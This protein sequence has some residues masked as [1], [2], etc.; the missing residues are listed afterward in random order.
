MGFDAP[1]GAV[2]G[3]EDA[4][5]SRLGGC[6]GPRFWHA[7]GACCPGFHDCRGFRGRHFRHLHPSFSEDCG[8]NFSFPWHGQRRFG[9]SGRCGALGTI[10]RFEALPSWVLKA[11]SGWYHRMIPQYRHHDEC[12]CTSDTEAAEEVSQKGLRGVFPGASE[13]DTE[14]RL[15]FSLPGVARELINVSI[16]GRILVVSVI[17]Q[18]APDC[19]AWEASEV[20]R[21]E[22]PSNSGPAGIWAQ[23]TDG[24]LTIGVPKAFPYVTH[25][26]E[27]TTK[28]CDIE[29]DVKSED[30]C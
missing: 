24:T 19:P 27:A 2:E 15:V 23:L 20:F 17:C 26:M 3:P 22:I 1:L 18:D 30:N 16:T 11:H 5:W 28:S 21:S 7:S 12:R 9:R 10:A 6:R 25:V 29:K 8:G 14:Y 4:G 13:T